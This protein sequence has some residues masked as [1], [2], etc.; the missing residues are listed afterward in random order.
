MGE[1]KDKKKD[2]FA[3]A[4]L[5]VYS[6]SVLMLAIPQKGHLLGGT[7]LHCA[8]KPYAPVKHTDLLTSR[9]L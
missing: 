3:L 1:S 8:H 2:M 4:I 7:F 9:R 6:A 5:E